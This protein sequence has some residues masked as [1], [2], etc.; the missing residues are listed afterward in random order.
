MPYVFKKVLRNLVTLKA[1]ANFSPGF[2]LKPWVNVA[3]HKFFATLKGL[4]CLLR[5]PYL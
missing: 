5:F 4:R 2:A 1:L 3:G